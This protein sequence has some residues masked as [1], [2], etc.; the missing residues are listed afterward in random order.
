MQ[1]KNGKILGEY[2]TDAAGRIYL[3]NI[4]PE[5]Y[6]ITEVKAPDGYIL[7]TSSKEALVEWGKTTTLQFENQPRNPI[8]V[9]KVDTK[10][11]EPLAGAKF[12]VEK[13]NDERMGDFVTNSAGFFVAPD[14]EAGT[15][16]VYETAAPAGYILD[17][18]PQTAVLKSDGT[19]TPGV[20][21]QAAGRPSDQEGGRGHRPAHE[22]RG[23]QDHQA[24]QRAGGPLC[25]R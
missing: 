1:I 13:S 12:R 25:H 16:T 20:F 7:L 19:T 2:R 24:E 5:L 17:K 18:T 6:V 8:L 22:G 15:Y 21:Q 3:E 9:K 4:D 10:T 14:L 11:G 23:V